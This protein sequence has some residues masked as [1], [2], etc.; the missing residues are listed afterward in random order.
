MY[1]HLACWHFKLLSYNH[2]WILFHVRASY[3]CRKPQSLGYT[4]SMSQRQGEEE[5]PHPWPRTHSL[6][7]RKEEVTLVTYLLDTVISDF[8]EVMV[9]KV[10]DQHMT[11]ACWLPRPVSEQSPLYV[12]PP[13]ASLG[14][15][16]VLKTALL[17]VPSH[18]CR[19]WPYWVSS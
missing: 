1:V 18:R 8:P 13:S 10:L 7:L 19:I 16:L 5:E 11:L 6:R 4:L 17:H 2:N 3:A 15:P 12:G 14:M 9:P